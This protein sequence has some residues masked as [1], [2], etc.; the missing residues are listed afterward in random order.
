MPD[1]A[2]VLQNARRRQFNEVLRIPSVGSLDTAILPSPPDDDDTFKFPMSSIIPPMSIAT[3]SIGGK[4]TTLIGYE[5]V[6][7]DGGLKAF[8]NALF[9][10]SSFC[11]EG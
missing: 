4:L 5:L 8:L 10:Q 11:N 6:F 2:T 1:A 9:K 3:R 7:G